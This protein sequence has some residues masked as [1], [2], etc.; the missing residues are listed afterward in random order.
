MGT[1]QTIG[2]TVDM[3]DSHLNILFSTVP[4]T[5]RA[6]V[7]ALALVVNLR[8]AWDSIPPM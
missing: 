2:L 5:L 4:R 7:E 1:Q 8:Q 6:K 3:V